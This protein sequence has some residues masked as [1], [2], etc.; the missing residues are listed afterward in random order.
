[1]K[2]P[3]SKG[4]SSRNNTLYNSSFGQ[5]L[6][7]DLRRELQELFNDEARS[8]VYLYRRIRMDEN[9]KPVRHPYTRTNRSGEGPK[10]VGAEGSTGT[11]FLYDDYLVKG[12]MNHS[13]AYAITKR[14][15]GP[16]DSTVE[17]RTMYFPYNF[18]SKITGNEYDIPT[19]YDRIARL[20]QDLE[21][22]VKSPLELREKYDIQSVDP[23]RLDSNGRIEY[24]RLRVISVVD[25]SFLV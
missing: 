8:A 15:E 18:L 12:F 4:S 20:E 1:M 17:L 22:G 3:Y 25:D 23:Y 13:Q 7:V 6:E 10:D 19:K 9:N 2:D 21:G 16:G 5:S 14:V 24:Y 11:G